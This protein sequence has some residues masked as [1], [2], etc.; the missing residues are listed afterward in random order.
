MAGSDKRKQS[1]YIP[2]AM[3]EEINREMDRLDRSRS[4]IVQRCIKIAL[5]EIKKLPSVNDIDDDTGDD[6][7]E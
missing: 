1:L 3:L 5:P 7:D 2:Q 4:W 6:E